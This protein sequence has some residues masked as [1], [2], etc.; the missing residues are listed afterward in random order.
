MVF[1]SRIMTGAF[2][3][4]QKYMVTRGDEVIY[5]NLTL[6]SLKHH[7]TTVQRME[8]GNECG[9]IFD[10]AK[11][12]QLQ[13]GDIIESYLERDTDTEKFVYTGVTKTY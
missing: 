10:S 5:E 2:D 6:A 9:V 1:G 8:R 4:K 13:R 3:T 12:L 11:D 7:K